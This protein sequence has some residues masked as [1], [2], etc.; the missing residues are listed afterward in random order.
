[1]SKHP[2]KSVTLD[3]KTHNNKQQQV[4]DNDNSINNY[5]NG[6]EKNNIV[7]EP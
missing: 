6:T 7:G 2:N 4:H 5:D 1:M 3:K